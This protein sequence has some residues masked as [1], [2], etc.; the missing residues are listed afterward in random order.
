VS[1]SSIE[2]AAPARRQLVTFGVTM[3]AAFA[4][5]TA[6]R[7]WRR[8]FDR[9]AMSAMIVAGLF[10]LA[11]LLIPAALA[12][13]H[14]WWMRLA[15]ILGW[16]N[17]RIILVVIFFLIV[18]PLGLLMRLFRRNPLESA[19]KGGSHWTEPPRSSYGD[20]HYEKQF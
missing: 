18:T 7:I 12:P 20:R 15:E 14:R 8:G 9:A 1:S 17:T 5:L 6:V 16:I 13:V 4:L 3:A 2:P 11:A 10:A 19:G